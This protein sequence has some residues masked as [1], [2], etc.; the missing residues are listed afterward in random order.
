MSSLA[1]ADQDYLQA[2]LPDERTDVLFA[3]YQANGTLGRE[4]QTGEKMVQIEQKMVEV[5]AQIHT[6]SGYSAHADQADLLAFI[7]GITQKPKE[8][9]LIH[10]E[11]EAKLS[12]LRAM[13]F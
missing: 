10:G 1:G 13:Q 3:G 7:Q 5:R 4:I 9:N 2:L 6:M 12:L 8:I 11:E